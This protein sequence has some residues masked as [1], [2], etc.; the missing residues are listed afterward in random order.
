ML[1]ANQVRKG[2]VILFSNEPCLVLSHDIAKYGRAG[3]H[4][5]CKIKGLKSGKI[6]NYDFYGNE[7]AEEVE[8]SSRNLQFLY[9]DDQKGYFMDQ[10]SYDQVEILLENIPG[11]VN[12]LK[13][14]ANYIGMF[15]EGNVISIQLP[16]KVSFEVTEAMDAVKGDTATNAQKEVVLENGISFKVPLFIK[17]GD[18]IVI[19]TETEEYSGKEN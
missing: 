11:G 1:T 7:K 14:G 17:K 8:V 15:Y 3:A 6:Y 2:L 19:N 4:N 10:A 13:E 5:R 9:N 12:Y 18:V 16:K